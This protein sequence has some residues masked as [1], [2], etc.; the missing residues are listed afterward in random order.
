MTAASGPPASRPLV[1]DV[2]AHHFPAG[3]CPPARSAGDPRWPYLV[4]DADGSAG[5]LMRGSDAFRVVK[6]ATW[7]VA[8]RLADLDDAGVGVQVISPVPVTQCSWADGNDAAEFLRAQNDLLAEAVA[9]SGGRLYGLG[10]VPLQDVGMAIAEL[11]RLT[12]E[13]GLAGVEI[14]TRIRDM[15][16]DDTALRPFFAVAEETGMPIFIH[17]VDG[18][19][20]T[21][22]SAQPYEFGIGM[23]TDT[24]LAA[25]ALVFG[26][27]LEDFPDLRIALAHGCGAFP[28]TYPRTAYGAALTAGGPDPRRAGQLE[29][30]VR[31][32]WAD[33]LVFAPEHLRLVAGCFGAGHLMLGSD[34]PFLRDPLR[35]ALTT[36][37]DAADQR[38]LTQPEA[39]AVLGRNAADFLGLRPVLERG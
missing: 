17:P 39:A 12:G 32:L 2:H 6:P 1:V 29:R 38:I 5:R 4:I 13:L 18:H 26:G 7:D 23:L 16:L 9:A 36:V 37:R 21:R 15:E 19:R 22:R 11:R 14:G 30:M 35:E 31:S 25:S 3:L 8:T 34:H 24:A 33:T 20:A 10:S 28:W 27:V